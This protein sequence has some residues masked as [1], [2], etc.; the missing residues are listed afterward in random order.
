MSKKAVVISG[1]PGVGKTTIFTKHTNLAILDSDSSN[2]SWQDSVN[3]IRNPEWPANY[4]AHIQ[5]NIDNTDAI[6]VSSH[7]EVRKALVA[8]NIKFV[9]VYPELDM[10]EEYI[11]RYKDRGSP[12]TFV[13]L[14]KTNYKTWIQELMEQQNC[15]HVVLKSGQYLSDVFYKILSGV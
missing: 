2:F 9:L 8:N 1:F 13:A 6:F 15:I 10:K 7:R 12:E 11:Q 5:E 3:R 4:I 14:L